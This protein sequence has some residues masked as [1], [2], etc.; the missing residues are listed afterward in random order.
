MLALVIERVSQSVRKI[1]QL[2]LQLKKMHVMEQQV[3]E[4]SASMTLQKLLSKKELA[5]VAIKHATIAW[6]KMAMHVIMAC[7]PF[8]PAHRAALVHAGLSRLEVQ[9]HYQFVA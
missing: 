6:V 3:V 7:L 5:P 1:S 9:V 4:K 2:P 8:P